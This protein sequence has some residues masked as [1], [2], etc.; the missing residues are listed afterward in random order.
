MCVVIWNH[1]FRSSPSG[2]KFRSRLEIQRYLEEIGS[3]LTLDQFDFRSRGWEHAAVKARCR[4]VLP[5]LPNPVQKTTS[6]EMCKW[7]GP[8]ADNNNNNNN[9]NNNN[10]NSSS[11]KKES[12]GVWSARV[13]QHGVKN[14]S[15]KGRL[16]VKMNFSKTQKI[17]R[18]HSK[19]TSQQSCSSYS[20]TS[21]PVKKR[22]KAAVISDNTSTELDHRHKGQL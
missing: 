4:P 18:K 13:V 16:V 22:K 15:T 2:R 19:S 7:N 21:V 3:D 8:L 12:D 14:S 5:S 9:S 1:L 20:E 10:N 6:D 11:K 17:H